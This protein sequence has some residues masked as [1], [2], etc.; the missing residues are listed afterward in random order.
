[1][2]A[3]E[4]SR[5]RKLLNIQGVGSGRPPVCSEEVEHLV[6]NLWQKYSELDERKRFLMVAETSELDLH[7]IWSS[8]REHLDIE[9]LA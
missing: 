7:A 5:R 8:L 6:W 3:C 9:Q 4:F 1:M 2:H